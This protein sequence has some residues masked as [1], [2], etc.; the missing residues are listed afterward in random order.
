MPFK[1]LDDDRPSTTSPGSQEQWLSAVYAST[2]M[3][4]QAKPSNLP[5]KTGKSHVSSMDTISCPPLTVTLF[6]YCRLRC[7]RAW[8]G[9]RHLGQAQ[10]IW[11]AEDQKLHRHSDPL[12]PGPIT[13]TPPPVH[14][15]AA[16]CRGGAR[17]I[18]V[19]SQKVAC[20]QL[21]G[22]DFEWSPDGFILP[23]RKLGVSLMSRR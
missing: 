21:R 22:K 12:K 15:L 14:P 7:E 3:S 5:R 19:P 13:V 17:L 20:S 18:R 11:D 8:S 23:S 9:S 2:T 1:N 10:G 6:L 16:H 4:G